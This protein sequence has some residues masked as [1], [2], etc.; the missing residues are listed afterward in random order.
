MLI[1]CK[2]LSFAIPGSIFTFSNMYV[3]D[4]SVGLRAFFCSNH[5]CGAAN[6][7]GRRVSGAAVVS[8]PMQNFP[9]Y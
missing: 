7:C 6:G 3:D 4:D 1:S 9:D 5:F 8:E 2:E